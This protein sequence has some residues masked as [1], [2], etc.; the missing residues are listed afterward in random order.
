MR[1]LFLFATLAF[2]AVMSSCKSSN[3]NADSTNDEDAKETAQTKAPSKYQG[4]YYG[5]DTDEAGEKIEVSIILGNYEQGDDSY[6]YSEKKLG[7]N[8]PYYESRDKF[9]LVDEEGTKIE[10]TDVTKRP[11]RFLVTSTTIIK[12]IND[13]LEKDSDGSNKHVLLKQ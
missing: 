1:K 10:L 8:V 13:Q 11:N 7:A 9:K 2:I 4:V 6:Y 5:I 3:E 12:L